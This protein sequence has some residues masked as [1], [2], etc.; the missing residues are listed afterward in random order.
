MSSVRGGIRRGVEMAMGK[1][2]QYSLIRLIIL[3]LKPLANGSNQTIIRMKSNQLGPKNCT[4]P[5]LDPN[6]LKKFKLGQF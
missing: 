2:Y 1:C 5:K 4:S 6:Q 3:L